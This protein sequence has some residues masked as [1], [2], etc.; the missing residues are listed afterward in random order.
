MI[1]KHHDSPPFEPFFV[2]TQFPLST[3]I[4]QINCAQRT[5]PVTVVLMMF[6]L[7][8]CTSS[9]TVGTKA[10][11]IG[12]IKSAFRDDNDGI[13]FPQKYDTIRGAKSAENDED[14][15]VISVRLLNRYHHATPFAFVTEN[16]DHVSYENV[17]ES[18]ENVTWKTTE[19][20]ESLN[21]SSAST[22]ATREVT[23]ITN[24]PMD[25][26]IYDGDISL[27][28]GWVHS[29][30]EIPESS[31][32]HYTQHTTMTPTTVQSTSKMTTKP[33]TK[34]STH[35]TT[36]SAFVLSSRKR[37][38]RDHNQ[39]IS[40]KD[41]DSSMPNYS[42]IHGKEIDRKLLVS[43]NK[44][45]RKSKAKLDCPCANQRTTTTTTST[46]EQPLNYDEYEYDELEDDYEI[47]PPR[48][49]DSNYATTT[50]LPTTTTLPQRFLPR[51]KRLLVDSYQNDD[52]EY[53]SF[54]DQQDTL[55]VERAERM[56]GAL[57]R[58]MG[59]VTIM[60]HVD[61]FIQKKTKQ[62]IRRLAKLYQSGEER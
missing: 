55:S 57:E 29:K 6:L 16:Q 32:E 40:L 44:K 59:F 42:D 9:R 2:Q 23:T 20:V 12:V 43:E 13:Y 53:G 14:N 51:S 19:R 46:T 62:S 25:A 26:D 8:T 60:S 35:P 21:V 37:L 15:E 31:E 28:H 22:T 5:F 33:S 27:E 47:D 41:V 58:I 56:Q 11:A 38:A 30:L 7:P 36:V 61:S 4:M 39:P 52:S 50:S 34:Q 1:N 24:T 49:Y 17:N 3:S 10:D 54:E 45:P 18:P 48:L